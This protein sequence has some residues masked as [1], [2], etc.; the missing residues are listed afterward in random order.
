MEIKQTFT[1]K[2]IF[3]HN[4]LQG[5]IPNALI[6]CD[7]LREL[8][9]SLNGF[10]GLIPTEINLLNYL[11][12]IKLNENMLSGTIPLEI[13]NHSKIEV[14]MLQANE[15][16]GSI[17]TEI[18]TMENVKQIVM[19]Y[20]MLKG[21]VP[22]E[23]QNLKTLELLHLHHNSLTG[24]V[25]IMDLPWKDLNSFITDCGKPW[26]ELPQPLQCKSCTICC[27]SEDE[28]Q[29]NSHWGRPLIL[30]IFSAIGIPPFIIA[31]LAY[32][33]HSLDKVDVE[34]Y[35]MGTDDI[36]SVYHFSFSNNVVAWLI[37]LFTAGVQIWLFRTFLGAS[38]LHK[39]D[40][41]W[42]YTIRCPSNS[43]ECQNDNSVDVSGW[44]LFSAVTSL[45]LGKDFANSMLQIKTA[46]V[47]KNAI[48]AFSGV[49]LLSLTTMAVFTSVFYNMA[50]AETN[51]D[52]IVNA[53][54]LLFINDLDEQFMALLRSMFP[55]WTENRMQEINLLIE[56]IKTRHQEHATDLSFQARLENGR[57]MLGFGSII[58][59]K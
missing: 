20:N 17:P 15:F 11:E 42:Q 28:C 45:Y 13:F 33:I 41:A 2:G 55:T 31:V 34:Q 37:Y 58:S 43:I 38:D 57:R 48:L 50:L 8:D 1:E 51:T 53:V 39:D 54:I 44:F 18:G 59:Q 35:A 56:K 32:I 9:L 36:N 21:N 40:T 6:A 30:Y 4:L 16:T 26:H 12:V 14:L 22:D 23:I 24:E 25:P 5:S 3:G 49:A 29:E 52:L 46:V 27:N 10:T 47:M 19:S 7:H